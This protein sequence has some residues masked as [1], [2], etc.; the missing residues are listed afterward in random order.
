M[1]KN[2]NQLRRAQTRLRRVVELIDEYSNKYFGIELDIYT[3]PLVD[4]EEELRKEIFLFQK[5]KELSFEDAIAGP[6]SEPVLIDNIGKVLTNLRIASKITQAEM[7]NMLDWE[8]PNLSRFEN[9]NYSSQTIKKV[10][11]YASTLG[12]YLNIFPSL[13]E[14]QEDIKYTTR[15]APIEKQEYASTAYEFEIA[16]IFDTSNQLGPVRKPEYAS[17]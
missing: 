7:A 17:V 16:G 11:Q 13:E 14:I 6:L 1:I 10:V 2:D 12:V 8:Q 15:D 9:E 3:L 5:L 4:E